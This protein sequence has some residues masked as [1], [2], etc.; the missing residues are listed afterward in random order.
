MTIWVVHLSS[1]ESPTLPPF[2]VFSAFNLQ[3]LQLVNCT[4]GRYVRL[5]QNSFKSSWADSSR[6]GSPLKD[7]ICKKASLISASKKPN[8]S[9]IIYLIIFVRPWYHA[10]LSFLK[11]RNNRQRNEKKKI[12][13]NSKYHKYIKG[14]LPGFSFLFFLQVFSHLKD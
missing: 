3:L 8:Y 2:S 1:D 9:L 14:K 13:E 11:T 6:K 5:K 4:A 12:Y 7:S 10:K